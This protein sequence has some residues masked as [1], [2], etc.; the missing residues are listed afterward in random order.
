MKTDKITMANTFAL[1]VGIVWLICAALVLVFPIFTLSTTRW[2]MH[3]MNVGMMGGWGMTSGNFLLGGIT[4]VV[5]AW[6][7]GWIFGWSWGQ[8][9]KKK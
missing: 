8:M 1:T 2:W 3:G 6:V 9:D 4:L 7:T 5:S